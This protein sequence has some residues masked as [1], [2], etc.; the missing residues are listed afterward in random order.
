LT[1][2]NSPRERSFEALE[3]LTRF[4]ALAL[5]AGNTAIRTRELMEQMAARLGFEAIAVSL[6]LDSIMVNARH[7]GHWATVMHMLG[8][9]GVDASRPRHLA[10]ARLLVGR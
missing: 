7:S 6:S 5:R 3:V 10:T 8:P 9:P 2:T 4:G 1:V